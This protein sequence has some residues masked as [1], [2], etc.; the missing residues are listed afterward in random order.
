MNRFRVHFEV[1]E[2]ITIDAETPAQARQ[3]AL[4]IRP[5]IVTKVKLV[6]ETSDA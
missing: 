3:G 4:A 2:P 1:G 6:K 5:G